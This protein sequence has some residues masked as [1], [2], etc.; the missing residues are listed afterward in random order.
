VL[1]ASAHVTP[2]SYTVDHERL[3]AVL[4]QCRPWLDCRGFVHSHPRG[5]T[6]LSYGDLRY[7]YTL[8]AAH[9]EDSLSQIL[10]PLVVGGHMFPYVIF[11]DRPHR[12]EGAQLVLF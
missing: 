10:M 12:P 8:F 6:Q 7:V 3:N 5:C 11:R 2:V 9:S 4:R 1:D